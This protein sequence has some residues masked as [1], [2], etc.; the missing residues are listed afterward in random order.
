MRLFLAVIHAGIF[1]VEPAQAFENLDGLVHVA[2][3]EE[4]TLLNDSGAHRQ[5][6]RPRL[7]ADT[8]HPQVRHPDAGMALLIGPAKPVVVDD[9]H[10]AGRRTT[11]LVENPLAAF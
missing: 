4:P 11:K 1:L 7:V 5:I 3:V 8:R 10:A 2:T 6:S 9:V